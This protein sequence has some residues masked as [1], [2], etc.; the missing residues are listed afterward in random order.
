MSQAARFHRGQHSGNI[1][2]LKLVLATQDCKKYNENRFHTRVVAILVPNGG[3]FFLWQAPS[4]VR[5]AWPARRPCG[6]SIACDPA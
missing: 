3:R 4:P 2:T 6:N 1:L 5:L